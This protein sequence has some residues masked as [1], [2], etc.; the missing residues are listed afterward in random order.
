MVSVVML[1]YFSIHS[2]IPSVIATP[3]A[4]YNVQRI[5]IHV[6]THPPI[7]YLHNHILVL[8]K[9]LNNKDNHT[10]KEKCEQQ[11]MHLLF[12]HKYVLSYTPLSFVSAPQ[13]KA[14]ATSWLLNLRLDMLCYTY[15]Q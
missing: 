7:I 11:K 5:I 8:I 2:H 13:S 4:M 12:G 1:R 14:L 9:D 10:H 6:I 15:M 3:H